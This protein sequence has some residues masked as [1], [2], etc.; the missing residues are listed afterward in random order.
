[1]KYSDLTIHQRVS[2]KGMFMTDESLGNYRMV[3]IMWNFKLAV[4]FFLN[5]D[6]SIL[7]IT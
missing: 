7:N 1:M 5:D 4:E 6:I 2:L 3:M